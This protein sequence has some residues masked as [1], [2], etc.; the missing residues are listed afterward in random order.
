[1]WSFDRRGRIVGSLL[2]IAPDRITCR[3]NAVPMST[4]LFESP[5][6]IRETNLL[7][8][9]VC[10]TAP[11]LT[12]TIPGSY[13]NQMV[14]FMNRVPISTNFSTSSPNAVNVTN[15]LPDGSYC[16]TAALSNI[17]FQT[18]EEQTICY[19]DRVAI[20]S[21]FFQSLAPIS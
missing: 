16:E 17:D 20:S 8:N 2:E 1:P 10:V 21:N 3:T 15:R 9:V 18:F 13:N 5:S 6:A 19:V 4:N 7:L 11:M 14:C 12:N